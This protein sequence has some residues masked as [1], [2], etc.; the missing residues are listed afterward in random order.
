MEVSHVIYAQEELIGRKQW[1]SI[2]RVIGEI[3]S[4]IYNIGVFY[5]IPL[6]K[7]FDCDIILRTYC[8]TIT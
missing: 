7:T 6:H 2:N 1:R 5:Y 3:I 4:V 8:T